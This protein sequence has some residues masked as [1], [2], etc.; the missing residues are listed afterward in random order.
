MS[1]SKVK[2]SSYLDIY[3]VI[4]DC[5]KVSICGVINEVILN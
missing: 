1:E 3:S 5:K 4:E 2:M